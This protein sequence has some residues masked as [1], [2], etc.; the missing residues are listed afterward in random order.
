MK[1]IIFILL[2]IVSTHIAFG[3]WQ[4]SPMASCEDQAFNRKVN[5]M[6]NYSVDVISVTALK[7]NYSDYVIFD[8]REMEEYLVSHLPGA[9]HLGY[10]Q[11]RWEALKNIADDKQIVLYC[12][13][14]YRSEKM[15]EKLIKK[16][17]QNVYNLYGSIFEWANQG[18]ELQDPRDHSSTKVHTYNKKWSKWVNNPDITITY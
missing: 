15:G 5:K 4:E 11:P 14:G 12:S 2:N 17:F 18:Y 3:Q 6:L 10:D 9:I 1:K 16:G 13:I 8:T 7:E